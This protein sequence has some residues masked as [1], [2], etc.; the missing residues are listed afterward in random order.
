MTCTAW[1]FQIAHLLMLQTQLGSQEKSLE[2]QM[3]A[4]KIKW[5][6]F[7]CQALRLGF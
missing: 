4:A 3:K 7:T 1:Y 5:K 2:E 6:A